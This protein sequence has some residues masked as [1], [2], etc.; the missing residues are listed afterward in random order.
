MLNT[1][2]IYAHHLSYSIKL[3]KNLTDNVIAAI[4]QHNLLNL[5][6]N[7]FNINSTYTEYTFVYFDDLKRFIMSFRLNN[8]YAK[9]GNNTLR[10][11]HQN[12]NVENRITILIK[13]QKLLK[14]ST[15]TNLTNV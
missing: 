8:L 3:S 9:Y 5:T 11:I 1:R 2:K 7:K 14:Y 12:L 15:E 13:K 6:F 4:Q 10:M